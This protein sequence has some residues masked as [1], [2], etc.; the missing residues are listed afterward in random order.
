[1][2][3]SVCVFVGVCVCV[4]VS[5]RLLDSFGVCTHWDSQ[6]CFVCL[7]LSTGKS[8]CSHSHPSVSLD[9]VSHGLFMNERVCV[10]VC[11]CVR[12]RVCVRVC[13]MMRGGWGRDM[14]EGE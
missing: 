14:G 12:V 3:V 1:M 9:K 8:S 4:C 6:P 10:C 11:V 2:S 13:V 5:L 7:A